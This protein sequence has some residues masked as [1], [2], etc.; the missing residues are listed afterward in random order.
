MPYGC[1]SVKLLNPIWVVYFTSTTLWRN[2]LDWIWLVDL[3]RLIDTQVLLLSSH[4]NT[5]ILI[6]GRASC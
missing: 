1:I 2:H 6:G 4:T 3:V 5:I